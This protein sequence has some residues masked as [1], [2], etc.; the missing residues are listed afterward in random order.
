MATNRTRVLLVDDEHDQR[1]IYRDT[2]EAAGYAVRC[3]SSASDA[4]AAVGQSLPD[5]VL[6][7]MAMPDAD[8]LWLLERLRA[9]VRTERLP[10]ILMSGVRAREDDQ[11]DGLARGADDYLHKPVSPGLLAAKIEAVLR[12]YRS[13]EELADVL[14]ARG[15]VLDVP[16]RRVAVDGRKVALTRKEFDLLTAFLRRRGEV[17]PIP[18]L[19]ETVWGYDLSDYADPHTVSVHVW[20]LRRKLGARLGDRIVALPGEGYRF[21]A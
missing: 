21:D 4:L 3:A 9:N 6:S 15:L 10:V 17:L 7:D 16:T 20:T 2:M 19:L 13:P 18:H 12:R 5:L 1:R 8:G 11:V 14:R